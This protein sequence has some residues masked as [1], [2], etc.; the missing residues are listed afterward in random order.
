MAKS[1][2]RVGLFSTNRGRAAR[3]VLIVVVT[4]ALALFL[5]SGMFSS[6]D[7]VSTDDESVADG[8]GG[9][10][11]T[12]PAV[13]AP[14]ARPFALPVVGG[15]ADADTGDIYGQA[16]SKGDDSSDDV[17]TGEGDE[18]ASSDGKESATDELQ[19]ASSYQ[20]AVTLTQDFAEAYGTYSADQSAAQWVKS[21]PGM[22][23]DLRDTV[24]A[25]AAD[26]WPD[27]V[28]RRVSSKAAV[29]AQ[30]V[31]PIFS[32]DGGRLV[33]LSVTVRKAH[34]FENQKSVQTY[35]YAVTLERAAG[36]AHGGWVVVAVS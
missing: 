13:A 1:S 24:A 18:D 27:M 23:S 36:G 9:S 15:V 12:G 26:A 4:A 3:A 2:N 25:D 14:I 31:D 28:D 6:D 10:E 20:S 5:V 19:R 21:L 11:P 16:L 17:T 29:V 34:S 22:S 8:W 7:Q 32:R 35:S 30:S 33:Q